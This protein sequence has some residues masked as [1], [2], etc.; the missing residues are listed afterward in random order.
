MPRTKTGQAM[1]ILNVRVPQGLVGRL[2]EHAT[3]QGHSLGDYVRAVLQAHLDGTSL[4][5]LNGTIRP[6]MT[7]LRQRVRQL[8]KTLT[9][10][11]AAR[12]ARPTTSPDLVTVTPVAPHDIPTESPADPVLTR[13]R[14]LRDGG[15]SF[16]QIAET[17]NTEGVPTSS[18]K[19]QWGHGAVQRLLKSVTV[20]T[21]PA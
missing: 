1:D 11:L 5:A 10:L 8:D 16:R 6:V 4:P 17:L 20:A 15:M 12:P 7:E 9:T 2:R 21:P 14:T 13:S 3:L 19:G 18:G